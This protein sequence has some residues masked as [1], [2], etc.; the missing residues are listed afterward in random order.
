MTDVYFLPL[1]MI[2][3]L[4]YLTRVYVCML[5][6]LKHKPVV[7]YN[8]FKV[9]KNYIVYSDIKCYK[10]YLF[11]HIAFI[12]TSLTGCTPSQSQRANFLVS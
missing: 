9:K 2:C 5:I 12:S 1:K 7:L 11:S 3:S 10:C 6:K 4:F 8:S